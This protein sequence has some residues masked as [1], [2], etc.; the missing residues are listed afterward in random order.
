MAAPLRAWLRAMSVPSRTI[1]PVLY[2]PPPSPDA[3]LSESAEPLRRRESA[4]IVL[5]DAPRI[6]APAP[7]Q[8]WPEAKVSP[9]PVPFAV[10][11]VIDVACI[12]NMPRLKIPPPALAELPVI[13]VARPVILAF[14]FPNGSATVFML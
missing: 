4:D 1:L 6:P 7:S 13:V 2:T 5:E 14:A 10:L 8:D 11:N 12:S 3:V 9:L